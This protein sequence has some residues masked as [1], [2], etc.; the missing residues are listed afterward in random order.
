MA[1]DPLAAIEPDPVRRAK[2]R[3]RMAPETVPEADGQMRGAL[4]SIPSDRPA[5][6][7]APNAQ[8]DRGWRR[9]GAFPVGDLF[10]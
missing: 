9:L 1:G 5:S 10:A 8:V 6:V 4:A 3:A 2:L 7:A